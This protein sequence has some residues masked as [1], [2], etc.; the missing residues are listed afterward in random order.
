MN[1]L[2]LRQLYD[3]E[4]LDDIDSKFISSKSFNYL[5]T[6]NEMKKIKRLFFFIKECGNYFPEGYIINNLKYYTNEM[7]SEIIR[8][9]Y[10][11][12]IDLLIHLV[13]YTQDDALLE[14]VIS[15]YG[16]DIIFAASHQEWVVN[17]ILD[18]RSLSDLG[19]VEITARRF[20]PSSIKKL[21]DMGYLPKDDKHILLT[22]DVD[23][24]F[25]ALDNGMNIIEH[26]QVLFIKSIFLDN[27]D[28]YDLLVSHGLRMD[29][30]EMNLHDVKSISFLERLKNT[31]HVFNNH[32]LCDI[33]GNAIKEKKNDLIDLLINEKF[34]L[35]DHVFRMCIWYGDV[36]LFKRLCLDKTQ[37]DICM[38]IKCCLIIGNHEILNYLLNTYNDIDYRG[39]QLLDD[40]LVF[41]TPECLK[42]VIDYVDFENIG[43]IYSDESIRILLRRGFNLSW[44]DEYKFIS[45]LGSD[46]ESKDLRIKKII[47]WNSLF[48]RR[49]LES[50]KFS[51]IRIL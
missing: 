42:L 17:R 33:F 40:C 48:G 3:D 13:N 22:E 14:Y 43:I 51:D 30:H 18:T 50:R 31:E 44:I 4:S 32:D 8:G 24:I 10:F 20:A 21:I 26:G 49:L 47:L 11:E 16:L 9:D 6:H 2:A 28:L 12:S 25:H 27:V 37:I 35:T 46:Y 1:E 5:A 41:V 29:K 36:D 34:K 7:L 38:L 45:F 15:R 23:L 39:C 19:D